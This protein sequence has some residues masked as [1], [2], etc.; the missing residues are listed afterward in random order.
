MTPKTDKTV[1]RGRNVA[2]EQKRYHLQ[3][4][5][6]VL[7]RSLLKDGLL[8]ELRLMVCPVVTG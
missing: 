3:V 7:F 8:D 4:G 2:G 6:A 1:R 5:S